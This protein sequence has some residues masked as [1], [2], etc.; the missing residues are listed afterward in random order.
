ME[1]ETKVE[2][3]GDNKPLQDSNA[4]FNAFK[5]EFSTAVRSIKVN[6][7]D[8]EMKFRDVTVNEQKTLSK[9]S[10]ENENRKDIIYDTQ[11][12]L[13]NTLCLDDGF[14]VYG[15]TEFDRIKIL[16][17]IYQ[18]NYMKN[19]ITYKCPECGKENVYRMDF[20]KIIDKLDNFDLKDDVFT[21][22]DERKI[23]KFTINYPLVRS[24]SNFYKDYMKKYKGKS[25][26]EM[27]VLDN[28]GNVEYVNL[29]IKRVEMIDKQDPNDRV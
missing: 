19:D 23:F 17:M 11:C 16:M 2:K 4:I 6:S 18:S 20:Q 24:V 22:E 29:Y 9:T 13:I 21:A 27:Q 25:N 28:L 8:K 10:I 15:L 12:Q 5:K 3:E 26:V 7:L 14:N 1:N